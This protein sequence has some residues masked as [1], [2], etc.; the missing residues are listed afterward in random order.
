MREED[1]L[2]GMVELDDQLLWESGAS[3][4]RRAV[5]WLRWV[6]LAA[7]LIAFITFSYFVATDR[8]GVVMPEDY[9]AIPETGFYIGERH[10]TLAEEIQDVTEENVGAF[11]DHIRVAGYKHETKAYRYVTDGNT[12]TDMVVI[13]F[14]GEYLVFK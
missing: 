8:P 9:E 11:V 5:S 10:Y 12:D 14:I 6:L 7:A 2:D 4:T 3:R 13:Y 1:M